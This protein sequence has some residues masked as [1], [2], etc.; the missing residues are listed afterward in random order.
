MMKRIVCFALAV[1]ML[2]G[3]TASAEM[4]SFPEAGLRLDVQEG[5]MLLVPTLLEEQSEF[6]AQLGADMEAMRADYA[7][8]HIVLEIFMERGSQVSLSAVQTEQSAQWSSTVTM[9][10]AD[11]DAFAEA[12]AMAPYENVEWSSAAPGWLS[13]DWTIEAGGIPVTFAGLMT[14]RQGMLYTLTASGALTSLESLRADNE[15]V[16][17]QLYFQGSN[18]EAAPEATALN[19]PQAIPD[20]GV[21]T[22]IALEGFESI[23]YEDTTVLTIRTLPGTELVLRTATDTLRGRA[24]ETGLHKFQV[25]TKRETV[26]AY[27]ISAT[28]EGRRESRV[29]VAVERQLT[30]EAQEAA[31]KR[32]ARQVN[33]YG[34]SNLVG[35]PEV[36]GG[37]PITFRGRVGGFMDLGGFPCVLIYTEN[38]GRGVWRSPIWV[39]LTEAVPLAEDDIRTVYGDL[40]GDTLPYTNENGEQLQAPV[41]VSRSVLE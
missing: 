31:Y 14:V 41:V 1:L 9:T 20:D 3:V 4:Y 36:Y 25:S 33:V 13:C 39:M 23:T 19:M 6:L 34:Y 17:A 21:A 15:A 28:A 30:L 29:D 26:Y 32:S 37:K 10:E 40:R 38:P 12:F 22:P 5:W 8:N 27:T 7:A 16:L 24:D 18:V 35:A 2:A 11:K